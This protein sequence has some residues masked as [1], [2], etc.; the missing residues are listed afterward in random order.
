MR[1]IEILSE[2]GSDSLKPIFYIIQLRAWYR[3]D[4]ERWFR[5][6]FEHEYNIKL[7]KGELDT[8]Q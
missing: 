3:V 4:V 5:K 8:F 2:G 6:I 7:L 1:N